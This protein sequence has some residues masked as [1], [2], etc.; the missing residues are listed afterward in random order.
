MS[1]VIKRRSIFDY[2]RKRADI[3]VIQETHSTRNNENVWINEWG[4]TI[5]FDHGENNARGVCVLIKKGFTGTVSNVKISNQGRYIVFDLKVE[6]LDYTCVAIYA[7]NKDTPQ[8]FREI[9]ETLLNR[10]ENKII[11]GDFNLVLNE[12]LDR[13]GSTYNNHKSKQALQNIIEH[14]ELCEVW[15]D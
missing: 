4:N 6:G 15:R 8:F 13:A 3:I 14:Y 5:L 11:I 10:G 1:D 9:D 2:Y 12:E 7:P